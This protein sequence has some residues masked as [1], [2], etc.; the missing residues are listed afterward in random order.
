MQRGE[1]GTGRGGVWGALAGR[2]GQL[3]AGERQERR[4]THQSPVNVGVRPLGRG[5]RVL[6][7]A[8]ALAGGGDAA[9]GSHGNAAPGTR[10]APLPTRRPQGQTT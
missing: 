10:N 3:G 7:V 1:A 6:S 5:R 2:L 4:Q 9:T 8:Q